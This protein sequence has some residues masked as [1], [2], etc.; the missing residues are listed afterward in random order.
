MCKDW[1]PPTDVSD[2]P[3]AAF[4]TSTLWKPGQQVTVDFIDVP[5]APA[6]KRAWVEKVV[7]EHVQPYVNLDLVF[8][9]YGATADIRIT[10]QHANTA[11]SRLGTQST[12]YKASKEQ[13]ESMNLGWLDEPH[14]GR[15]QWKGVTYRFPACA[16]WCGPDQN[17]AVIIHEF[18]HALGMVHEHQNP[19][20]GIQWNVDAVMEY[21]RGPPNHWDDEAIKFNVLDKYSAD[22][23]NASDFD[24]HSVMLYAYPSDLTLNGM[25]TKANPYFSKTDIQ[26]LAKVY[27]TPSPRSR[28]TVNT[29][30]TTGSTSPT[31]ATQNRMIFVVAVVALMVVVV[32]GVVGGMILAKRGRR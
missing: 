14:S 5:T 21:F 32:G 23:V 25:S 31:T 27:G 1:P 9:A 18:G 6:W 26:W 29:P 12:W 13:P 17:G 20:G 10:F 19:H 16:S 4:L 8:G 7:T 24:P 2:L 30:P 28:V 3:A 15:F 11:Y 22:I